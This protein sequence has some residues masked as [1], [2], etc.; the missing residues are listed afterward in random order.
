MESGAPQEI[1]YKFKIAK[2]WVGVVSWKLNVAII[3]PGK[4]G[5]EDSAPI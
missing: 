5:F 2:K 3:S 4:L 1:P